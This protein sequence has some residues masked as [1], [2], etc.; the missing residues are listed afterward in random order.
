MILTMLLLGLILGRWWSTCLVVGTLGW[1]VLRWLD[2]VGDSPAGFLSAAGLAFA[3][4]GAC[5]VVQPARPSL[6]VTD[7]ERITG[8][9]D[10]RRWTGT[11]GNAA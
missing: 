5:V 1:P 11:S 3:N 2:E 7:A 9:R 6:G 4:A 8:P 10:S